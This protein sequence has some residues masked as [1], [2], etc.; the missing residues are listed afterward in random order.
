MYAV[1]VTFKLK[2]G[3]AKAFL[4]LMRD[5]AATSLSTEEGCHR[6]DVCTDPARPEEVFLYEL[7]DDRAA[8]DTHLASAHFQTFDTTAGPMISSKSITTYA[9]VHP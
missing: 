7:Y 1:V 3:Q 9:Q 4:A 2:P 8:F 5:N 6:F